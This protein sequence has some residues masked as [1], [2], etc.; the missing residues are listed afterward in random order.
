[1]YSVGID[2]HDGVYALC[3]LDEN[4]GR[5]KEWRA[6]AATPDRWLERSRR[7]PAMHALTEACS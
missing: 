3:I 1:M 5:V 4:G 6:P 7:L 2:A